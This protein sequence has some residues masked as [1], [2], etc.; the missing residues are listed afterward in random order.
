MNKKIIN[1]K[2]YKYVIPSMITM[3]LSGFYSIID[4]LFVANAVNDSALA[5]INIA[6]PIQV[7]LNATAI[8]IGIGGAVSYSYY[9]G[10]NKTKQM[11]KTIG[12]T[13]SLLL[14]SGIILPIVLNYFVNDLLVF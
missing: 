7:I 12:V 10:Q 4:G 14:I 1:Q 9:N 11:H 6:Y 3:L 5:A 8:G 2:F 13:C